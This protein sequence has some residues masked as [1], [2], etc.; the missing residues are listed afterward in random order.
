MPCRWLPYRQQQASDVRGHTIGAKGPNDPFLH[1]GEPHGTS[2]ATPTR[3]SIAPQASRGTGAAVA[4]SMKKPA[5]SIAKHT[6][7]A[8]PLTG[9]PLTP[10]TGC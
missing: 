8:R 7:A 2:G 9:T 10:T 5:T 6:P 3:T 1:D 4:G